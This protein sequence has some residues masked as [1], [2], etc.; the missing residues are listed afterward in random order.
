MLFRCFTVLP[1]EAFY[2]SNVT[3]YLLT[4]LAGMLLSAIGKSIKSVPD[5]FAEI[6]L[7]KMRII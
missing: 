6:S 5:N 1:N 7:T 2:L 3:P 4:A